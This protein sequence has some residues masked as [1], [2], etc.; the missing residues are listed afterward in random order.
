MNDRA[1]TVEDDLAYLRSVVDS[2]R[3]A[4]VRYKFGVVYLVSGLVWGP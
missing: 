1:P 4:H 2:D 3:G